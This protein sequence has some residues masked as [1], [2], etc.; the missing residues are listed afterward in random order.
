MANI[1]STVASNFPMEK[2]VLVRVIVMITCLLA[3][4]GAIFVILSYACVK[5]LRTQARQILVNLSLMDFGIGA[6][7]FTGAAVN[8][9][10]YYNDSSGSLFNSN[11]TIVDYFC[12]AQASLAL[13]TTLSSIFWTISLAVYIY[14][15]I[16]QNW[17]KIKL[18]LPL[19]YI[20][21]YGV[22]IGLSVWLL[23]TKRLGHAPYDSSGWCSIR[24]VSPQNKKIDFIAAIFGYD[25]WIYLAF[26][27]CSVIYFSLF[28][29]MQIEV[30]L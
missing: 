22:P 13:L 12:K 28:I 16:F 21:C 9:D 25:L 23:L 15:L 17:Q 30:S 18:Y 3:M 5:S 24:T 19:C 27:I 7:N 29:R 4:M 10:Q 26:I 20:I 8:F 14:L 2:H 11:I 1:A 6:A